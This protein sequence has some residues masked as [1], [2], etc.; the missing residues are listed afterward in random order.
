MLKKL[1]NAYVYYVWKMPMNEH[2]SCLITSLMKILEHM[3]WKKNGSAKRSRQGGELRF[4][5]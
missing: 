2:G 5:L 4:V 1:M 3:F